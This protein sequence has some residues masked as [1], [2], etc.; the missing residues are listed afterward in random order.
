MSAAFAQSK[1]IWYT[2]DYTTDTYG[3]FFDTFDY[4]EGTVTCNLSCDGDYTL[5]VNDRYVS[6]DQYNDFEHYKIY[7]T[8]DITPY[9]KPGKNSIY[10]LGWHLGT[11]TFRYRP[12]MAGLIYEV[13]CGDTTLACSDENTLSRENPNYKGGYCK[14]ITSQLG[15][16]FLYDSTAEANAALAPAVVMDKNATLFPRPIVKH[17]LLPKVEAKCLKAEGNHYLLDLG[18]ETLGLPTLRFCSDS[19][20][21]ILVAWGEHIEDGCVR[22]LIGPRDFSFEYIAHP[23]CNEYTNYML[24]LGGRYLEVF[25]EQPIELDYCTM[26]PQMYPVEV[27]PKTLADPLDQKIYDTCVNTLRFCMMEHYTDTPWREQ[28][29]YAFDSRNQM[30]SGYYAFKDGNKDY[31]RANLLLAAKD[32]RDDNILS[33]TFPCGSDLVIPSFSLHYLTAVREYLDHTGDLSLGFETYD[34]MLSIIEAFLPRMK[35]GIMYSF[36]EARY[37]NFFDWSDHMGENIGE[38]VAKPELMINCLMII[39]LDHFKAIS[40]MLNKA[41]PYQ[42]VLDGLRVAVKKTFYHPENGLFSVTPGGDEYTDLGNTA[43]ILA[44]VTEDKDEL[45]ILEKALLSDTLCECSLSMK[46]LKYDAL[47]QINPDNREYVINE[48][49]R[50]YKKMLDHGATSFWETIDGAAAFNDAGSLCHGWSAIPIC[51]LA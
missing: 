10:I 3:D 37:W 8:V 49:R 4:Q 45:A 35:D 47:L 29:F 46:T 27:I 6:S 32:V 20:Q 12:A 43:A 16:S 39:A 41:F 34:K 15:N 2:R 40:E 26:I 30:L 50:N 51:Y 14:A 22:R 11:P 5:F 1:W 36:P 33:I 17:E 7:D 28:S 48:I 42:S 19:K 44:K 13:V 9:V 18:S 38:S 24:T 31:V 25:A 21:K 23:G